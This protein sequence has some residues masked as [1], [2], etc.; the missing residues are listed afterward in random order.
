MFKTKLLILLLISSIFFSCTSNQ[1][2]TPNKK[3][4]LGYIP[5]EYDG[6]LFTNLLRNNLKNIQ[7]FDKNSDIVIT[8]EIKHTDNLFITNINNTSDRQR[9][10][11]SIKIYIED[12]SG[13]CLRYSYSNQI[14]QFYIFATSD[15]F[16]SNNLA[17]KK[18]KNQNTEI[19]VDKFINEVIYKDKYCNEI[20]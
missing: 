4:S 9:I 12:K 20:K 13:K 8:G 5:G 10:T 17:E 19:L 18:I 6:L 15:K 7:A 14:S 11:S 2:I 16:L 1:I 3:Y